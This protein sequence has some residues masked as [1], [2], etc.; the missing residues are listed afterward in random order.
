[1]PYFP[2]TCYILPYTF[3]V[4]LY[5]SICYKMIILFQCY[6][7]IGSNSS[8]SNLLSQGWFVCLFT[9][10]IV[11][12]NNPCF[13][14]ACKSNFHCQKASGCVY[15]LATAAG[16]IV[17]PIVKPDGANIKEKVP[18]SFGSKMVAVQEAHIWC[19]FAAFLWLNPLQSQ[20][21]ICNQSQFMQF[22]VH[23]PWYNLSYNQT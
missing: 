22:C 1:M 18:L 14:S 8:S 15:L 19:L 4:L 23:H 5:F 21:H 12:S 17:T 3:S 9:N 6:L 10:S 13:S 16:L 20:L 7:L 2:S 11:A